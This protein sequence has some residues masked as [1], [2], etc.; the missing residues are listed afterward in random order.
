MAKTSE[1]QKPEKVFRIGFV[2]A[3]IFTRKVK[4][5]DGEVTLRSVNVQ[6]RYLD[7]EGHPQYTSSL[8]LAE[9]PQAIE[10][11]RLALN[12]MEAQEAEII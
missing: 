4:T 6:K 5:D 7:D 10:V 9:L 1:K 3:S 11:L 8:G 2:S 12:H